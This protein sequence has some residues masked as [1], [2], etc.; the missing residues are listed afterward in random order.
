M[1]QKTR[2]FL[3]TL[4]AFVLMVLAAAYISIKH[5]GQAEGVVIFQ[6]TEL[7]RFQKDVQRLDIRLTETELRVKRLQEEFERD[8]KA[9]TEVIKMYEK[10]M[11]EREK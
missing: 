7:I 5:Q 10:E 11:A 8:M 6:N 9:F 3:I 1:P 4:F 2:Y